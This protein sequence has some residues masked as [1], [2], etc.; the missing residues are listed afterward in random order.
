MTTAAGT[1]GGV[2]Y[3][4]VAAPVVTALVPDAGP[5]AGGTTVTLT[6][7]GLGQ[8]TSVLFGTTPAAF[9]V[10]SDTA[11]TAV[12]PPGR[13][14]PRPSRSLHQEGRARR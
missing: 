7:S 2:P 14:A 4:Y 3:L 6:G 13:P 8:T 10:I 5:A 11:V 1:S 12:V 9:T